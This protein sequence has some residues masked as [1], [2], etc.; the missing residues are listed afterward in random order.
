MGKTGVYQILQCLK[1]LKAMKMRSEAVIFHQI[2]YPFPF[3]SLAEKVNSKS[4]RFVREDPSIRMESSFSL[5]TPLPV[6]SNRGNDPI[7]KTPLV[8]WVGLGFWSGNLWSLSGS[9]KWLGTWNAHLNYRSLDFTHPAVENYSP[10]S[11]AVGGCSR[12]CH[13]TVILHAGKGT[14]QCDFKSTRKGKCITRPRWSSSPFST[15]RIK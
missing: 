8:L 12:S 6:S 7:D 14:Q 9:S 11:L 3:M 5:P 4:I 2:P 13:G 10:Q 1:V 15:M